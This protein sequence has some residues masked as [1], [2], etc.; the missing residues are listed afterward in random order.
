MG[1]EDE[2]EDED[3]VEAAAV[4][5]VEDGRERILDEDRIKSMGGLDVVVNER[6]RELVGASSLGT[7]YH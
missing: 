3:Q 2:T 6:L 5:L 1:G 7:D 4:A